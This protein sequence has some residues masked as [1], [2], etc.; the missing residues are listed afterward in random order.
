MFPMIDARLKKELGALAPAGVDMNVQIYYSY[1]LQGVGPVLW[2]HV[3]CSTLSPFVL[4]AFFLDSLEFH[5]FFLTCPLQFI[6]VLP[7]SCLPVES[8]SLDF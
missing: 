6:A 5:S 3:F 1:S 8:E 4:H 2:C 7:S